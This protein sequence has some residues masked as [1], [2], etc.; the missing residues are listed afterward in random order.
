MLKKSLLL[1]VVYLLGT[2]A[3]ARSACTPEDVQVKAQQFMELAIQLSQKEPQRYQ[4]VVQ[5]MQ[6][7]LP[8]FQ[9]TND[10]DGLCSFYEEW[11]RKIQ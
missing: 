7:K 5:A 2:V 6:A 3:I 9:K 8:E 10:L 1:A 4:E 11:I